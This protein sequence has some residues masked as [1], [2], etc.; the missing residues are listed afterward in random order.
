MPHFP[1][2][3]DARTLPIVDAAEHRTMPPVARH[4]GAHT[5]HGNTTTAP[6]VPVPHAPL[7]KELALE[8]PLVSVGQ[9]H[10][11]LYL[12][13]TGTPVVIVFDEH[14]DYD[15]YD[16]RHFLSRETWGSADETLAEL[17]QLLAPVRDLAPAELTA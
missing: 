11:R 12:T 4:D 17:E 5:V 15:R 16:A 1:P 8:P 14:Q 9:V 13:S 6:G 2:G 3:L 7:V 10:H